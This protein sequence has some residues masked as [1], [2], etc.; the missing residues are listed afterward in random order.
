MKNKPPILSNK[1]I[2]KC[3]M[4]AEIPKAGYVKNCKAI[5]KYTAEVQ[6]DADV[7]WYRKQKCQQ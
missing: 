2:D 4:I 3:Y 1:E 5:M 7:A 6:R